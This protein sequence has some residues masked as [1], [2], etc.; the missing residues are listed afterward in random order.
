MKAKATVPQIF[1]EA[2]QPTGFGGAVVSGT[3]IYVGQVLQLRDYAS[4]VGL[5]YSPASPGLYKDSPMV[6]PVPAAEVGAL[7]LAIAGSAAKYNLVGYALT[8]YPIQSRM[9]TNARL[10]V[11][12]VDA[13]HFVTTT[14][15]D[16]RRIS[17]VALNENISLWLPYE[18]A[19]I[20]P[21]SG[22]WATLSSGTDGCVSGT[23]TTSG[24]LLLGK[25]IGYWSGTSYKVDSD[26]RRSPHADI[27]SL[28][29]VQLFPVL[30]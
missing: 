23:N 11:G 24:L 16:I 25:I 21:T 5:D 28:V 20:V 4:T 26:I 29:R 22:T 14:F 27:K 3:T 15:G 8:E 19:A 13:S 2:Y 17:Y 30:G 12:S 10:P 18:N 9:A 1:G 7:T 6:R